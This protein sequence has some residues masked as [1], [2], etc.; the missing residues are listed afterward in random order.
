MIKIN[1]LTKLF[2]PDEEFPFPISRSLARDLT[3][4]YGRHKAVVLD[5]SGIEEIGQGFADE[6]FRVFVNQH[7]EVKLLTANCAPA[8]QRMI[9]HVC[10]ANRPAEYGE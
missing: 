8:V 9:A 10:G 5:F 2:E 1:L 3:K 7:P 4:C 6:L